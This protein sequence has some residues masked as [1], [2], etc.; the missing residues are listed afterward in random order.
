MAFGSNG[1]ANILAKDTLNDYKGNAYEFV[2]KKYFEWIT[3]NMEKHNKQGRE[4]KILCS[5]N[6]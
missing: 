5:L 6:L 2:R 3:F 4:H 1:D